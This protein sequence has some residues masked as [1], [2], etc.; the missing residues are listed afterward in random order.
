MTDLKSRALQQIANCHEPDKLRQMA[1]NASRHGEEE[2]RKAAKL[3]LYKILPSEEPGTLEYDV[4]QSIHALEG[5]LT[6]E[7]GKTTRLSRTRQKIGRAG[8]QTTVADLILGKVSEG[9]RMLIVRQMPELTFEAVA[10]R[11][12][13]R[14][15]EETLKAAEARLQAAMGNDV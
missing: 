15:D 5:E 6:D 2:V 4:W 8:E 9:F 12:P 11:H 10:L 13:E 3:R 1:T 7:R 14:F